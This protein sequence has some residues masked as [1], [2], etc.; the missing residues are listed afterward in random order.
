VFIPYMK[1]ISEKFK[2]VVN[3]FNI[4]TMFKTRHTLSAS[5]TLFRGSILGPQM[6]LAVDGYGIAVNI[7]NFF[8]T[9]V[10]GLDCFWFGFRYFNFHFHFCLSLD[11]H[12]HLIIFYFTI[13]LLSPVDKTLISCAHTHVVVLT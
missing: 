5:M 2:R 9:G 4:K 6:A 8:W 10:H 12:M 7:S 11:L 3:R 13:F 1:G